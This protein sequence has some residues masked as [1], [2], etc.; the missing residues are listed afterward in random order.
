MGHRDGKLI[1]SGR[2][3]APSRSSP[4]SARMPMRPRVPAQ[5]LVGI[6]THL[7]LDLP[8]AVGDRTWGD[9]IV[10]ALLLDVDRTTLAVKPATDYATPSGAS[11]VPVPALFLIMQLGFMSGVATSGPK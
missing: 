8:E 6:G 5:V 3:R 10:T 1:R 7:Q 11:H 9:Y 2:A 4:R